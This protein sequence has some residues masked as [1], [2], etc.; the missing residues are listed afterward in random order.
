MSDSQQ[1]SDIEDIYE[2]SPMQQGMLFQSLL[3]P[4]SGVFFE[5]QVIR[6]GSELD[7]AAFESAWQA[8]VDETPVLR[9][10]FF[11]GDMEKPVQVVR[12]DVRLGI[13][14]IDWSE[15]DGAQRERMLHE[16]LLETRRAGFDL[17]TP[18]L[19]RLSLIR[20]SPTESL[21]VWHFHHLLLDGWSGQLLLAELLER[22]RAKTARE[23]YTPRERRPFSDY[24]GWLQEQDAAAAERF[25]T[26]RL[27]GVTTPTAIGVGRPRGA[28]AP[29]GNEGQSVLRLS[30]AQS[31][32]LRRFARENRLTLNTLVQGAWAILLA[33]YGHSS[34]VLFGSVVSGRPP[35]LAGIEHM[36]GLFINTLP[37][38]V[39][40]DA[41]APL[42]GWL[43]ELQASQRRAD[44][45]QY[46]SP[47]QLQQWSELPARTKPYDSVVVFE[48]FPAAQAASSTAHQEPFYLGRTDVDLT[49]V[50]LPEDELRVKFL[51]NERRFDPETIEAMSRHVETLLSRLPD[52]VDPNEA[53]G[54]RVGDLSL[55]SAEE[56]QRVLFEWNATAAPGFDVKPLMQLLGERAAITPDATAFVED[57]IEISLAEIDERSSRLA[58]HLIGRGV[59]RGT[60][61]GVC[62][63]RSIAAVVAFLG[64]L[65]ARAAYLPLDPA[66]PPQRLEHMLKDSGAELVLTCGTP[67]PLGAGVTT[68][69]LDAEAAAI[70]G[71]S[72]TAPTPH[73]K[74][75][76]LAYVLYTSGST[77]VPKGVAVEHRP[78]L[79]RLDWMWRCY[80]F[81]PDEVGI[82]RTPLNFV[83]SFWELLGCLL[84]GVPTVIAT[85]RTAREPAEL[86]RLLA[87]HGV[88]RMWFVP[89]FLEMMLDACPDLGAR[90]PALRF[91][92]SGGEPLT[93]ELYRRFA[94]AAPDATLFNVYGASELWDA[95]IFDPALEGTP[96]DCVPIGRPIAN[97]EAYV[98][99]EQL[100]PVPI[101]VV[102]RLYFGGA[103]LA[104]GYVQGGGLTEERFVRHPFSETPGAR[105]YDTGDLARH[106][107]DGSIT[108]VGRR[109]D[110]INL[111]G[112][113]IEPREVQA[114]IDRHPAV[115]ES[116][117]LAREVLPGDA[118]L[119]AYVVP[120]GES[121]DSASLLDSL[122]RVLPAFLVPASVVWID[123]MP[124]TPSGKCD[125]R[126]LLELDFEPHEHTP[127]AAPRGPVEEKLAQ[128][129]RE[130]LGV[131]AVG[132]RDDFFAHLG[133]H[134][135]LATRLVSRVRD[136]L[137]V[138]LPL[139]AVFDAPTVAGL[140]AVVARQRGPETDAETGDDGPADALL[141]DL[142]GMSP[143]D[144][145][146]LLAEVEEHE[147]EGER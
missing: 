31:D 146:A 92:S 53:S 57:G 7:V 127:S 52:R 45:F 5:Q 147:P 123:A 40:V 100:E 128:H 80:P 115:S 65:K 4:T 78:I 19:M 132:R 135:L 120:D 67:R 18:P 83:D 16:Y 139:R 3:A 28:S 6:L 76:D 56:R 17:E 107:S 143:E 30:R 87:R 60:I 43:E 51:Y 126:Q 94:A 1:L 35:E 142:E 116:A 61:V 41:D 111:R 48:N 140:A 14:R 141:A 84:Q 124:K 22:Y 89:S 77:G 42:I 110:Q 103:C 121:R 29:D 46:V 82:M 99:D 74:P 112:F 98:L 102:G 9:S 34:D 137:G 2:L 122:T 68:I 113:R 12:K 81:V 37:V 88:T 73:A 54:V 20:C 8:I 106:T 108:L 145:E 144:V 11:W 72:A 131:E 58:H 138:E 133:G 91:W 15:A 25:W 105:L 104:R 69:D 118:R 10:S 129:F 33:R 47:L 21:F 44:R 136:E 101:G 125:R 24:V 59:E 134:S 32:A 97:T 93:P 114:W 49:V 23:S 71:A 50:V 86:A 64:I 109:D 62:I 119:V 36:I 130:L 70:A 38:R 90:L 27:R 117:V 75:G 26:E 85:E 55:L 96:T 79:N 63:E 66:Y 95:T 13:E 39:E